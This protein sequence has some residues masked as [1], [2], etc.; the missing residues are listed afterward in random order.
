MA[1]WEWN[2]IGSVQGD[3]GGCEGVVFLSAMATLQIFLK[4]VLS[5][6][7]NFDWPFDAFGSTVVLLTGRAEGH[8]D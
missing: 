2:A 6:G 3:H 8:G 1:L 5:I 4:G 7:G